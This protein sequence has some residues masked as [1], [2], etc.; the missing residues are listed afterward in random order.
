MTTLRSP[1]DIQEFL[2]GLRV[3]VKNIRSDSSLQIHLESVYKSSVPSS[4]RTLLPVAN[5]PPLSIH[6]PSSVSGSGTRRTEKNACGE[7]SG[8][9]VNTKPKSTSSEVANPLK[10]SCNA[11]AKV[12][13]DSGALGSTKLSA[14]HVESPVDACVSSHSRPAYVD[15]LGEWRRSNA[16]SIEKSSCGAGRKPLSPARKVANV[17]PSHEIALKSRA[18]IVTDLEKERAIRDY[19]RRMLILS[20]GYDEAIHTQVENVFDDPVLNGSAMGQLLLTV[21]LYQ[22]RLNGGE[23]EVPNL[24][25]QKGIAS[26]GRS[27]LDGNGQQKGSGALDHL[28]VPFRFPC[29]IQEVRENYSSFIRLVGGNSHDMPPSVRSLFKTLFP[30]VEQVVGPLEQIN[31]DQAYLHD[32]RTALLDLYMHVIRTAL[33]PPQ[34]LPAAKLCHQEPV[35]VDPKRFIK[36]K[37]CSIMLCAPST[38]AAYEKFLCYYL[39][40]QNL[41]P[42]PYTYALPGDDCLVPGPLAAKFLHSPAAPE[43]HSGF[44]FTPRSA[45]PLAIFVPSVFPFLTNGVVWVMYA[46]ALLEMN[47]SPSKVLTLP[48]SR[49]TLNPKTVAQCKENI[50]VSLPF[51]FRSTCVSL[52]KRTEEDG[53][54]DRIFEG[55]RLCI[56]QLMWDA[57]EKNRRNL[58][59]VRVNSM[60]EPNAIA[61]A[62]TI[63]PPPSYPDSHRPSSKTGSLPRASPKTVTFVEA[64]RSE[65]PASCARSVNIFRPALSQEV[66][67]ADGSSHGKPISP[68]LEQAFDST[69]SVSEREVHHLTEWLLTVLGPRYKY[70]AEDQSFAVSSEKPPYFFSSTAPYST[71]SE[72]S[73]LFF[74]DGV[75]LAHVIRILER[76]RCDGL[77]SV[78]PTSKRAAK[79]YNIGRCLRFLMEEHGMRPPCAMLEQKL[80]VGDSLGVWSFVRTLR[81][82]Y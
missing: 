71:S 9:L 13:L 28:F 63:S 6:W 7:Q 46:A 69:P 5:A 82:L 68:T 53:I 42:D 78:K 40:E 41:L 32:D 76:R 29:S 8:V 54:V 15:P 20:C 79:R 21:Y 2:Q 62:R 34:S 12:K 44:C 75:F 17:S 61:H 30:S 58:A 45:A 74:S 64:S 48:L 37:T 24:P 23:E 52:L 43:M 66:I 70:V 57:V 27:S 35:D 81:Q 10:N 31:A 77:D 3:D 16:E 1:K 19:L 47:R 39:T 38:Y 56:L 72:T 51:F 14:V 73:T 26:H 80:L 25:S 55:D 67:E 49:C 50:R 18:Q 11:D 60:R 33:P 22:T 65:S 36:G 59:D 4:N